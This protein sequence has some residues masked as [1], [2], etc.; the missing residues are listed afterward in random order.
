MSEKQALRD[1]RY[2][3]K[4]D[5]DI[6]RKINGEAVPLYSED[7]LHRLYPEK[8][9]TLCGE[10]YE[11]KK[12]DK[13]RDIGR[14]E[15][16]DKLLFVGSAGEHNKLFR[17]EAG[18]AEVE[19][20]GYIALLKLRLL[21]FL[22][23]LGVILGCVGIACLPKR[24][25]SPAKSVDVTK[26]D[27]NMTVAD[28]VYYSVSGTVTKDGKGI[29]DATLT[30]QKG[31]TVIATVTTD[32]NGA[33]SFEQVSPGKYNVVCTA[34]ESLLTKL[35]DVIGESV[36][37]NFVFPADDLHDVG[38]ITGVS[39]DLPES[40][41]TEDKSDVKAIVKHLGKD[42]PPVAVGGL[43]TEAMLHM[44]VGKEV[45]LTLTV[46][47]LDEE[48]V[49]QT[50]KTAIEKISGE[51]ELTYLDMSLLREVY[52]NKL[53]ESSEYLHKSKTVL[54]IAVP[55]DSSHSAGTYVFRY[56]DGKALRFEQLSEKPTGGYRDG[57]CYVSIDTV[58]LYTNCFSTYAIGAANTDAPTKG[59]DMIVF[60]DGAL[61]NVAEKAVTLYYSHDAAATHNCR[62]ELYLSGKNEDLL[63]AQSGIIP[64]GNELTVMPL[65]AKNAQLP[66]DGSYEG[67]LLII[68]LGTDG[69]TG[70]TNVQLPQTVTITR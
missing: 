56:H 70:D 54:E 50:D 65:A 9:Y 58:Y 47:K 18:Y 41:P 5:Y 51:L 11:S 21:P 55:F 10:T 25:V 52:K 28:A 42:T 7:K 30:L 29:A 67:Y 44:E 15:L 37:V 31:S 45:D 53:L 68:Y 60:S 43:D 39:E 26:E 19:G 46:E 59:S 69:K 57:T 32:K 3:E 35:A 17:K 33:Y 12:R 34:G 4:E 24:T 40:H 61:V 62:V 14:I 13:D 48:A 36:T 23:L 22:I 2:L 1:F 49:P 63:V 27:P 16:S 6:E 64:P 20:G 8:D 38:D 66:S